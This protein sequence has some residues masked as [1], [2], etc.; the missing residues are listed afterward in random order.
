MLAGVVQSWV[1]EEGSGSE[2]GDRRKKGVGFGRDLVEGCWELERVGE[3]SE[4]WK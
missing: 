4:N 3:G 1:L 2:G